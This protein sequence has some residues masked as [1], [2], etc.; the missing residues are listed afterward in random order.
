MSAHHIASIP[1]RAKVAARVRELREDLGLTHQQFAWRINVHWQTVRGVEQERQGF[2]LESIVCICL[3]FG[4]SADWLL[5]LSENSK[6][7]DK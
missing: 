2:R 1:L 4:V 6:P 5:G 7:R 3:V